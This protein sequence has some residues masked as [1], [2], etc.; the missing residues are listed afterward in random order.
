MKPILYLD[1]DGVLVG[2][3]EFYS[4]EWWK[5]HPEG[6]AAYRVK[7]CLMW[8]TDNFEV[9]W[10]TAWVS[11]GSMHPSRIEDLQRVLGDVPTNIIN[12]IHNPMERILSDKTSA[13]DFETMQ[14]W[15]WFD[16]ELS[17]EESITLQKHHSLTKFIGIN[18]SVDIY[19][20]IR[21]CMYLGMMLEIP[22][23]ALTID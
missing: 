3:P 12:K 5:Q 7:N 13:I 18:T 8:L 2:F 10:L 6:I 11:K 17:M 4:A 14:E 16:D 19:S 20:L 23:G 22:L 15:Y 21:A 1:V 9:R